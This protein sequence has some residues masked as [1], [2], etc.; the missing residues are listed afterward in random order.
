LLWLRGAADP[1]GEGLEVHPPLSREEAE[2]LLGADAQEALILTRY[3][4]HFTLA[5]YRPSSGERL[6]AIDLG[7]DER[8]LADLLWSA[9]RALFASDKALYLF[10]RTRELYL[11]E[12][13]PLPQTAT[14]D[15]GRL[16]TR[17]GTVQLLLPDGLWTFAV[18]R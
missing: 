10:D 14:A 1:A 2:A 4:P 11:L 12:A 15:T 18:V 5:A 17:G 16:L 6:D 3:G 7:R 9:D 8:P 13:L